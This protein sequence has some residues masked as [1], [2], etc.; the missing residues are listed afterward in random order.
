MLR[1]FP[2]DS[3]YSR[4]DSVGACRRHDKIGFNARMKS[5]HSRGRVKERTEEDAVMDS[6]VETI[7]S[8]DI[9]ARRKMKQNERMKVSIEDEM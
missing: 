2:S 4:G 3:F 6:W 7:G 9:V 1:W 8:D 5:K